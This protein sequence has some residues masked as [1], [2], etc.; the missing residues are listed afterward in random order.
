M[1]WIPWGP[2][3]TDLNG[4]IPA[5]KRAIADTGADP[6]DLH[7]QGSAGL[8]RGSNRRIDV[9]ASVAVVPRIVADG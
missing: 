4:A 3:I 6:A 7:V 5:M 9:H 8:L 2:A 1:R